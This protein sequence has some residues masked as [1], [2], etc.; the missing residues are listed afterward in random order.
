MI[1]IRKSKNV[2]LK[3]IFENPSERY[4]LIVPLDEIDDY[5]GL[6]L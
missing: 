2:I 1:I 6:S 4:D 3:N 5:R